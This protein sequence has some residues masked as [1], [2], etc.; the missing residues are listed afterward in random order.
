VKLIQG[1]LSNQMIEY[2]ESLPK[3]NIHY[4]SDEKRKR[5]KKIKDRPNQNDIDYA[6]SFINNLEVSK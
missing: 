1:S 2:M 4:L 3:E 6:A 5:Y